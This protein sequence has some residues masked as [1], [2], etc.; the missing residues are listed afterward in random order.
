LGLAD[1]SLNPMSLAGVKVLAVSGIARPKL[2]FRQLQELGANVV[3][4]R[5]FADHHWYHA[6]DIELL[7]QDLARS[8]AEVVVTTQKDSVRLNWHLCKELPVS[9]LTIK[10]QWLGSIPLSDTFLAKDLSSETYEMA[11]LTPQGW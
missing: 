1:T 9:V 5:A 8:K 3:A 6:S 7:K 11:N 4:S 2:F 10:T